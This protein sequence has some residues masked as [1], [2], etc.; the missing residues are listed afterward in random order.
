LLNP[1]SGFN[2]HLIFSFC[3]EFKYFQAQNLRSPFT[4]Y[5]CRLSFTRKLVFVEMVLFIRKQ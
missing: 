1:G 4:I 3:K 2:T 5:N